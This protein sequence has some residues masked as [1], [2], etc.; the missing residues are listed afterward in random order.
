MTRPSRDQRARL[1]LLFALV[2]LFGCA[3]RGAS[4]PAPPSAPDRSYEPWNVLLIT[5][6]N[7][8]PD[9]MSLYGYD[10]ETTPHLEAFAEEAA[11]F[12][13]AFST[14]AWTAPGIVSIFTGYYPPVHAQSGRF[15]YYDAEMVSALRVLSKHGYATFGEAVQGP[16]H[17]DFGFERVTGKLEDFVADRA[18]DE[19]EAPF[20]AWSHLRD[21]HLPYSPTE[22]N[23]RRFGATSRSSAGVD[24]VRNHKVILR[25]PEELELDIAHAGEISFTEEDVQEI[26]ALYDA[27]VA[28]VDARLGRL[29]EQMRESGLLDRTIVIIAADHGE[30]LFEHGWVGHASTGYDGKVYD[31]LIRIPLLIRVPDRSLIGRSS[32]LVQGVDLM[33]TLFE[34]LGISSAQM[35]PAIQGVSLVPLIDGRT[36]SVRDFVYSQTTRKG[37][38]TPRNE[39]GARVTAVRSPSHKLIRFPEEGG[40]GIEGFDLRRDPGEHND[41]YSERREEFRDLEQALDA[42]NI[43]NRRTAAELVLG[44]ANRRLSKMARALL[45]LEDMALAEEQWA[46]IQSM[47]ETWSLEPDPFLADPGHAPK[48]TEVER[49]GA[50]MIHKAKECAERPGTLN[51]SAEQWLEP[52]SWTCVTAPTPLVPGTSMSCV[53]T[54]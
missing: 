51:A 20:F 54:E 9:R 24:A 21:V 13:S 29:F 49:R 39:I 4:A 50:E 47:R 30:E 36:T 44:A 25:Y 40:D 27:E 19:S 43:D 37:W 23:A 53:A 45:D 17:E 28:D 1:V 2:L 6:D 22:T 31:E 10:K 12:E 11:V 32:S 3:S 7:L 42:W 38:T 35:C 14:S 41:V 33:P 48:W 8:R 16:S 18:E 46:A 34:L 5:V 15:S 26:R 52:D